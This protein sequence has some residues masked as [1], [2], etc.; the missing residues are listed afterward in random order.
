M[1]SR[2]LVQ[3]LGI[4]FPIGSDTDQHIQRLFKVQNPDTQQLALHAVY[5]VNRVA[6]VIYR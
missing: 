2:A 3:R 1:E 6:E 4:D 5:I